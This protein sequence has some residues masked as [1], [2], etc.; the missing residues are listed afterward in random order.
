MTALRVARLSVTQCPHCSTSFRVTQAQIEAANGAVRCG[1]C[2][3]VFDA[4]KHMENKE[5]ASSEA[6][7][8]EQSPVS[9]NIQ[10]KDPKNTP[11]SFDE[12]TVI[13]SEKPFNH[14]RIIINEVEPE[15][16]NTE[17][18]IIKKDEAQNEIHSVLNHLNQDDIHFFENN[19]KKRKWKKI[20][21]SGS[22]IIFLTVLLLLQYAWFQ[23][24]HLSLNTTLRPSYN[25]A[26]QLLTCDLPPLVDIK[27]IKSLQLLVRSH[28]DAP[29]ALLVDTVIINSAIHPQPYPVLHLSFTDING[30]LV[31]NRAFTSKEYLGGELAGTKEM[32]S[33]R[34]IRLNLEIIDPGQEAVNYALTFS[35][36]VS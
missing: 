23:R 1:S 20:I 12:T 17:E 10:P 19:P 18:K 9:E 21:L 27:A 32:P 25:I 24:G 22:A 28:P 36:D 16:A 34:P 30:N 35:K 33:S 11:P 6:T 5:A 26:C 13:E 8:A 7:I 14:S 31:A 4:R 2:L 15:F 3:Q 29:N